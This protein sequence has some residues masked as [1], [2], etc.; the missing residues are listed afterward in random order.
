MS[1][2]SCVDWH[3]N[4]ITHL[5]LQKWNLPKLKRESLESLLD[6]DGAKGSLPLKGSPR[7]FLLWNGSMA[8]LP[9]GWK[10]SHGFEGSAAPGMLTGVL[11]PEDRKTSLVM[12]SASHYWLICDNNLTAAWKVKSKFEL[13]IDDCRRSGHCS[14]E[15]TCCVVMRTSW[16]MLRAQT[17]NVDRHITG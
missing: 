9:N 17:K 10:G 8:S 5:N 2:Q 14:T 13:L 11:L 12:T 15:R 16:Q 1:V 7:P 4:T 3:F 6:V